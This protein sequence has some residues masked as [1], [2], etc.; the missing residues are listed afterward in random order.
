MKRQKTNGNNLHQTCPSCNGTGFVLNPATYGPD[1]RR[2]R[3]AKGLS[4]AALSDLVGVSA[5]HLCAIE[6]Q[7][8]PLHG[9][10]TKALVKRIEE[11]LK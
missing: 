10:G 4:L 3:E 1:M 9:E 5:Q 7:R 2:R 8:V 6:L 11:V